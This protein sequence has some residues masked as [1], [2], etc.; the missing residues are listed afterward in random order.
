[1][2]T[3]T[4]L[5]AEIWCLI[6]EFA[7]SIPGIFCTS[8][9][10][11]MVAFARDGYN[12]CSSLRVRKSMDLK[13]V[14]GKVCSNW[15]RLVVHLIFECISIKNGQQASQ[16]AALLDDANS[17]NIVSG[18][19][20]RTWWTRRLELIVDGTATWTT[21]HNNAIIRILWHCPNLTC[22]STAFSTSDPYAF[23][24]PALVLALSKPGL[25]T[26]I[27][28][29][30]LKAT[31]ML[32]NTV[33]TALADSLE[34]IWVLPSRRTPYKIDYPTQYLPR[35]HTFISDVRDGGLGARLDLPSL[36]TVISRDTADRFSYIVRSGKTIRYLNVIDLGSFLPYLALCPNLQTLAVGIREIS[37]ARC[38]S[39]FLEF[40]HPYLQTLVVEHADMFRLSLMGAGSTFAHRYLPNILSDFSHN[41]FPALKL[42]RLVFC[43]DSVASLDPFPPTILLVW[44]SWLET[45]HLQ[46]ISVQVALCIEQLSSDTWLPLTLDLVQEHL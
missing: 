2:N 46:G 37:T 20:A 3:S 26:K 38:T 33:T 15:R 19:N 43:W 4:R 7:T 28:R 21:A 9:D 35:L 23:Y 8:D 29:I 41:N 44:K 34:V 25:E 45:C 30:E 31:A 32:F 36:R 16:L 14:I 6:F 22:F 13:L 27:K 24:S 12:L 18:G 11:A 1:M 40:S 39:N 10:A 42:I 5:P 17:K